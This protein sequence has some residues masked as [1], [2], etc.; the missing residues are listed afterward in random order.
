[1]KSRQM[2]TMNDINICRKLVG[3]GNFR[4]GA[5]VLKLFNLIELVRDYRGL[6]FQFLLC[7]NMSRVLSM[8]HLNNETILMFKQ[9]L[10]HSRGYI[11]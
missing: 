11:D 4:S 7:L 1:M 2:Q 10:K 6:I 3:Y 5:L 9:N 8:P